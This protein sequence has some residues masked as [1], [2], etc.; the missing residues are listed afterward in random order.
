VVLLGKAPGALKGGI[1]A[2][3]GSGPGVADA[4]LD[5]VEDLNRR[6][7]RVAVHQRMGSLVA[8]ILKGESLESVNPL[9]LRA[10]LSGSVAESMVDLDG[11]LCLLPRRGV[12][13]PS[14]C[15][16]GLRKGVCRC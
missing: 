9:Q 1:V 2:C 5:E 12:V 4:L 3:C 14:A 15:V 16:E 6:Q 10:I 13:A 7:V 8:A 11:H